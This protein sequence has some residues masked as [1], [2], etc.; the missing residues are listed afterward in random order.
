[1]LDPVTYRRTNKTVYSA[2]YH[3]IW[4][5]KYRRRVLVGQVEARLKEVIGAVIAASGGDVIELEVMPDH[6]HLLVELPPAA[7]LPR[8]SPN[9]ASRPQAQS[10]PMPVFDHPGDRILSR[11]GPDLCV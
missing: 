8:C 11:H 4:C 7:H 6:V 3:L 1:M 2:K 10:R 9:S 5:P